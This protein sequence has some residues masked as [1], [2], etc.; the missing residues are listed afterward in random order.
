MSIYVEISI[1]GTLDELRRRTQVPV[2]HERWDLRFTSIEYLER[3]DDSPVQLFRYSTRIGFGRKIEGWG[4]MVGERLDANARASALKFGSDDPRSLISSGFGYWKFEQIGEELRFV[5]GFD[6]DVRWGLIGRVFDCLFFRPL[7]GWATAWS[8]DRLRLWIE[9]EKEPQ[10]AARQALIHA[11][12]ATALAFLWTWQG[13]VP[14]LWALHSAEVELSLATGI[15]E[16]MAPWLLRVLGA[17]EVVFGL[18]YPFFAR[19]GWPWLLTAGSM[20]VGLLVVLTAAPD[21]VQGPFSPLVLNFSMAALA[22]I[23][24]MSLRDLPSARRCLRRPTKEQP[25]ENRT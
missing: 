13:L 20:A 25:E 18:A 12:A 11:V 19:R 24:L 3:A 7:L 21:L 22:V 17:A 14:K 8:F 10:Q 15:P 1:R 6:Y 5:T 2:L 23:G 9:Q 4:E 16:S